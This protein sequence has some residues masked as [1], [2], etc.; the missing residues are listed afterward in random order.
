MVRDTHRERGEHA[1]AQLVVV[2]A[3]PDRA[4]LRDHLVRALAQRGASLVERRAERLGDLE[5]ALRR[6][7][8][9]V[10]AGSLAEGIDVRLGAGDRRR[11][12][13]FVHVQHP[14]REELE[15]DEPAAVRHRHAIGRDHGEALELDRGRERQVVLGRRSSDGLEENGV[16]AP[17]VLGLPARSLGVVRHGNQPIAEPRRAIPRR[18]LEARARR[19]PAPRRSE[20]G[21]RGVGRERAL[22]DLAPRAHDAGVER[23]AV[24]GPLRALQEERREAVVE[25]GLRERREAVGIPQHRLR[26]VH[27]PPARFPSVARRARQERRPDGDGV[28]RARGLFEIPL[29]PLRVGG[30]RFDRGADEAG[31]GASTERLLRDAVAVRRG[32]LE[33]APHDGLAQLDVQEIDAEPDQV[34][35]DVVAGRPREDRVDDL[36]HVARRRLPSHREIGGPRGER[37]VPAHQQPLR[38]DQRTIDLRRE[39]PDPLS[40]ARVEDGDLVAAPDEHALPPPREPAQP[41]DVDVPARLPV[42]RLHAATPAGSARTT[43]SPATT[44]PWYVP[45]CSQTKRVPSCSPTP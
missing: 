3:Q 6:R 16:R 17:A 4:Q 15:R 42:S 33:R 21:R 12:E 44:K 34:G 32:A 11:G 19:E 28:E 39:R 9:E 18:D 41:V 40:R 20:L 5:E 2:G 43:R 8:I 30:C 29:E 14:L 10:A 22:E 24:Q 13:R 45:S 36:E 1:A 26:R 31:V 38:N 23:S 7:R 37:P 35:S 25:R 27:H